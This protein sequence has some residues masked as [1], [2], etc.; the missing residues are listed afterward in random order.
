MAILD[1]NVAD[2]ERIAKEIGARAMF[3]HCD[4]VS[5]SSVDNAILASDQAFGD[6]VVGGVVHCAGVGSVASALTR[7]GSA[8]SLEHFKKVVDINLTGSFNVACKPLA[9]PRIMS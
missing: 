1:T 4:I 9:P 6:R 3:V 7:E 8:T 2:G 5:E